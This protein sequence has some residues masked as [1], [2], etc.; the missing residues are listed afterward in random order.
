MLT[1]RNQ[2]NDW[3]QHNVKQNGDDFVLIPKSGNGNLKQFMINVGRDGT[4]HQ[5]SAVEQNDQRSNYQLRLQQ[6]GAADI[7][8]SILTPPKGVTVD[9]Q[10]RQRRK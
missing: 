6:N 9:D 2:S 5:F 10:R 3:Q 7:S 8:K 4:I 1:A